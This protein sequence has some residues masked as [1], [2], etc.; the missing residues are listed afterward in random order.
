M[1]SKS[2]QVAVLGP[3]TIFFKK[4]GVLIHHPWV[5]MWCLISL[6]WAIKFVILI[7]EVPD[8]VSNSHPRIYVLYLNHWVVICL[9]SDSPCIPPSGGKY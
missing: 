6:G 8:E 7:F 1:L 2:G 4:T 3:Y 9:Q 5:N